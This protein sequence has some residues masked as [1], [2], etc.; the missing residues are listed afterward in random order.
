[1]LLKR[2]AAAAGRD[3]ST[4]VLVRAVPSDRI[5]F[6][7]LL[8]LVREEADHRY[9]LA[10]LNDFLAGLGL[11]RLRE[12]VGEADLASLSPFLK[13]YAAAMVEHASYPKGAQSPAW[14]RQVARFDV[15]RFAAPMNGFRLYLLRRSPVPFKRRNIFVDSSVGSRV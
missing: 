8:A 3:V 1:M 4:Y 12:V 2:A 6:A 5:G 15:S 11:A 10:E 9:V 14:T 13:N 7:E